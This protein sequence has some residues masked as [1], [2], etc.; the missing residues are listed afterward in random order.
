MISMDFGDDLVWRKSSRSGDNGGNCVFVARQG[1]GTGVRDSKL[2]QEGPVLW[3]TRQ[4]WAS[5]TRVVS[6]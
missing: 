5:L 3:M 4:D 1:T 6:R 2:G